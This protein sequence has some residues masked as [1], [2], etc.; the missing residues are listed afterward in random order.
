MT[1]LVPLQLEHKL[2]LEAFVADF[3]AA[4]ETDIP[5][6]FSQPNWTHEQTVWAFAAWARGEELEAGWVPMTTSFLMFEGHLVGVVNLRHRLT[7][8]L[9]SHGGH[10]GYS[11]APSHRGKGY[12][13][14]LLAGALEQAQA[15]GISR[16]LL[17]CD[18]ANVASV[19]VIEKNGG[20][21]MDTLFEEE[22]ER[23]VSR[24]W[25]GLNGEDA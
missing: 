13:T 15:L 17:T 11:V 24:F 1:D 7:E 16:A 4:G 25:I 12:G 5:A 22:I 18:P 8:K 14:R 23:Q 3:H 19:R 20:V 2:L 9:E 10:V 6:Y 21:Y